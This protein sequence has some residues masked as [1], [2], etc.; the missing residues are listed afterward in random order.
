MRQKVSRTAIFATLFEGVSSRKYFIRF[1]ST[2]RFWDK[3]SFAE[4]MKHILPSSSFWTVALPSINSDERPDTKIEKKTNFTS[5]Q[6]LLISRL[7]LCGGL[8]PIL[9]VQE[10]FRKKCAV[11]VDSRTRLHVRILITKPEAKQLVNFLFV[12]QNQK[13]LAWWER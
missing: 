10:V 6:T 7:Y 1:L 12:L 9:F 4:C 5:F 13:C 3:F 11:R 8:L 2:V